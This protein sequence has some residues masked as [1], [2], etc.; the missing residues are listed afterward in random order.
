MLAGRA[1]AWALWSATLTLPAG[2]EGPVHIVARA[3]DES[4]N[5]QPQR[6]EEVWNLRGVACN[7]WAHATVQ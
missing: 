5:T 3:T 4:Y 2:H 7:S 1:W 6:P